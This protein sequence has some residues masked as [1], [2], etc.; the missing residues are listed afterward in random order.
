MNGSGENRWKR[1]DLTRWNRSGLSAL[2][3]V[4]GTAADHLEM[5]RAYWAAIFSPRWQDRLAPP[6]DPGDVAADEIDRE[7]IQH[8]VN[9]HLV[10][11]YLDES[12]DIGW[13]LA[14]VFARSCHVL[15]QHMNAHANEAFV[16]TAT[17]WE[18]V[19][20]MVAMLGYHP[21]GATSAT[22]MLAIEA[23]AEGRVEKGLQVRHRPPD[24][25]KAIVFETL[26]DLDVVPDFNVLRVAGH[27]SSKTL[28]DAAEADGETDPASVPWRENPKAP[29]AAT[30][31]TLI[32][33]VRGGDA[34]DAE[35]AWVRERHEDKINLD[36]EG[37]KWR[38]WTLGEVT[39]MSSPR[40]RRAPWMNGETVRRT[41]VPHGLTAGS[42]I[43]W[44]K[45][46]ELSPSAWRFARVKRADAFGLELAKHTEPFLSFQA[47]PDDPETRVYQDDDKWPRW[48][49][50]DIELRRATKLTGSFTVPAGSEAEKIVGFLAKFT[51]QQ[52]LG[53]G[54]DGFEGGTDVLTFD[55]SGSSGVAPLEAD[56]AGL[57][58][59]IKWLF[60]VA[61]IATSFPLTPEILVKIGAM[62]LVKD[63]RIPSTGQLVFEAFLDIFGGGGAPTDW[64][65][66]NPD[67][68]PPPQALF[69]FWVNDAADENRPNI[70]PSRAELTGGGEL[71][72]LP[73]DFPGTGETDRTIPL[74]DNFDVTNAHDDG[75]FFFDG[76]PRGLIP[77]AWG[78]ARF[79]NASNVA[80]WRA[81]EIL[82]IESPLISDHQSTTGPDDPSRRYEHDSAFAVKLRLPPD[83]AD[84]FSG[85]SNAAI[86]E[87]LE[88]QADY[89]AADAPA[90]ATINRQT[91]T[92]PI[93]LNPCPGP[94]LVGRTLLATNDKGE[95]QVVRV[96]S[97]ADCKVV[98]VP[99]LSD[100]F[101]EGNLRLFGNVVRAGHG[102]RQPA[103]RMGPGTGAR[104][105]N[106]LVL[107][108]QQVSTVPDA[109]RLHGAREDLEIRVGDALWQP[110]ARLDDSGPT[111]PH[112]VVSTTEEGFLNLT[113]GDGRLG[114]ALPAGTDNVEIRFR[115]GAGRRGSIPAGSLEQLV[116]PHPL[117]EAVRQP[118]ASA[119]GADMELPGQ[120]RE[121]APASLLALERAVSLSDFEQLAMQHRSI[122]QARAVYRVGGAGHSDLVQV[123]AVPASGRQLDGALMDDL[124]AFLQLRAVPT[125]RVEVAQHEPVDVRVKIKV[126]VDY[127][128]SE[129]DRVATAV[130]HAIAERFSADRRGIGQ[131]LQLSELY[132][133]VESVDGVEDSVCEIVEPAG[134]GQTV[135]VDPHQLAAV[136]GRSAVQCTPSE[137]VP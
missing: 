62:M 76:Q 80:I 114:R 15:T 55:G 41:S 118:L 27:D 12:G 24:G 20:K 53:D 47:D 135:R 96:E 92:T 122:S 7:W 83:I 14:R 11:Q 131:P 65:E 86:P 25:G 68:Q 136:P 64:T 120:M 77:G 1:E 54:K 85:T 102:E 8:A 67:L 28:L 108:Q 36:H 100:A 112:Y 73:K 19:R 9:R 113:F 130:R 132:A 66:V 59:F 111:E 110:V 91:L 94:E 61:G 134:S 50:G 26:E 133:A 57:E 42:V 104:R 58:N 70:G 22:T 10:R 18:S 33:K 31:S 60:Q 40:F 89:R 37:D 74:T 48:G 103:V 137:Y 93:Q 49:D 124:A 30:D 116:K 78:A 84:T 121:R 69:R 23:R 6:Y 32:V 16:R 98:L 51:A 128:R 43:A 44:R 39:F 56:K 13:T 105:D 95:T 38:H 21:V 115:T 34:P 35:A 99:P 75:W 107:E 4:D 119:G 63:A 125:A 101:T 5:I 29:I 2:A 45:T 97:V 17:E 90:G 52:M 126:R 109:R 106:V 46:G 79:A 3:Y 81:V 127:A 117:V 87:L 88:L 82:A 123:V 72:Y 71:W 129:A